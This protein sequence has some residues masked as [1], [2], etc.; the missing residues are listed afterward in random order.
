MAHPNK[1]SKRRFQLA[2]DA[3]FR[4]RQLITLFWFLAAVLG[5]A[6][7]VLPASNEP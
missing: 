2:A 6:D 4:H 7:V 5:F 1:T 3:P